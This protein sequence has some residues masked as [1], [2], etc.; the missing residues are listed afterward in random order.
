MTTE[1]LEAIAELRKAGLTL[2]VVAYSAMVQAL[3]WCKLPQEA[4]G[5]SLCLRL[6]V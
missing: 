2:D 6:C 4:E 1:V 3:G 5:A